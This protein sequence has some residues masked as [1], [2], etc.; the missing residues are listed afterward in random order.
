MERLFDPD[1]PHFA[2]WVW[3][4]DMDRPWEWTHADSAPN[5]PKAAP[6]YYASLCGFRNLVETLPQRT[7]GTSTRVAGLRYPT[8]MLR[9]TK[10]RSL[11]LLGY[12]LSMARI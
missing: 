8:C 2:T 4:Y 10:R 5:E 9:C 12:Y 11:T 1:Q 7:Q 3:L 6:L